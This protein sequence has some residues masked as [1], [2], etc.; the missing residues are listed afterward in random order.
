MAAAA[1]AVR[2]P[3][4]CRRSGTRARARPSSRRRAGRPPPPSPLARSTTR[5]PRRTSRR[6]ASCVRRRDLNASPQA[7]VC[8]RTRCESLRAH[9]PPAVPREVTRGAQPP[10]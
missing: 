7:A 1:P 8:F 2:R 9:P 10:L 4:A 5:R 3:R 6:R